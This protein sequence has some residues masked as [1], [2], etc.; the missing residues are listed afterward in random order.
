MPMASSADA[1]FVGLDFEQWNRVA[2]ALNRDPSTHEL[3]GAIASQVF[4]VLRLRNAADIADAEYDLR[5][6]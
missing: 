2:G 3:A 5:G 4:E 6:A 1:V